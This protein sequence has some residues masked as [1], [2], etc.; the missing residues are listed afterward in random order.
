MFHL[1]L[2]KIINKENFFSYTVILIQLRNEENVLF[3]TIAVV[4]FG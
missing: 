1:N 3:L 4:L 2:K